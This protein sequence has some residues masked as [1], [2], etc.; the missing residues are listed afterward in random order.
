MK[1]VDFVDKIHYCHYYCHCHYHSYNCHY[2]DHGRGRGEMM[3]DSQIE[4][5]DV[6]VWI[7]SNQLLLKGQ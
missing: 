5:V 6:L 1:M 4:K 3:I 2:Q 7:S